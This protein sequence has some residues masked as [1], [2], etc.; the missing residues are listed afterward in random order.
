[1][2]SET[3]KLNLGCG[4]SKKDGYVNLDR[5]SALNPDIAYDLNNFPY[6]FHD[7]EF[8]LIEARHVLEHLRE[9]F[10]VMKELHR[11]LKTGGVLKIQVPHFSRAFTHAE[12][13]AGFDIT[14]PLYFNKNF[15]RSGFFGVEFELKKMR[16]NW[17]ANLHLMP[18]LGYG[19]LSIVFLKIANRLVSFFANL[20][21]SFCSRIWCFYVGGFEEIDFEFKCV[22]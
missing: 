10:V 5:Q 17:L 12:H 21:P 22:K 14:F 11:I 8:D 9:P 6:P 18:H 19:A 20:S 4:E 16:L 15:T 3:K 2:F 7:S 1:M 13:K